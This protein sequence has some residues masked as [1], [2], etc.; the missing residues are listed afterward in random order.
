MIDFTPNFICQ[1][2]DLELNGQGSFAVWLHQIM[3]ARIHP[4]VLF[5]VNSN[6]SKVLLRFLVPDFSNRSLHDLV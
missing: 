4:L 5:S 3:D 2:P 6:G 1:C